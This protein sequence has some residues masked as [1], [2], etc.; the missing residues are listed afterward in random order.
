MV[1]EYKKAVVGGGCFW[2]VE[3]VMQRVEGV[4]EVIS[5]FAGGKVPNPSYREVCYGKTGHAEVVQIT[6]DPNKISY[7]DLLVIFMTTHDPTTLNRQG[8]D[9][10]THYRSIIL[11]AGSEQ[12]ITAKKVMQDLADHFDDPIVTE[13]KP[14]DTFYPAEAE[15]QNYYNQHKEQGYCSF[16]IS[17]KVNKL[18][19]Q[20]KDKLK[21]DLQENY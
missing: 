14:L 12:E 4:E 3:A 6:F 5:G 17:P 19:A 7:E 2:C 10:G 18:K 11:P 8:A 16:V 15:H 9:V 20:Y 1:N 21:A 13:V